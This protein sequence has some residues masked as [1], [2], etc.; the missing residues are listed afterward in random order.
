M[1]IEKEKILFNRSTLDVANNIKLSEINRIEELFQSYE[2]RNAMNKNANIKKPQ[3]HLIFSLKKFLSFVR[4]ILN[5]ETR[6][7][8]IGYFIWRLWKLVTKIS[9]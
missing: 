2:T 8:A 5:T 3:N 4:S 6:E 7:R 1:A 9:L